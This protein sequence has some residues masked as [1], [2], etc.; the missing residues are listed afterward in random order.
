MGASLFSDF[1]SEFI[2]LASDLEYTSEMLIW[3]FK[4]KLT[5]CLQDWLNSEIE[6]LKTIS[7]LAKYY[8]SIYKQMQATNQIREKAKSFTIV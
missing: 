4:Y 1:Y 3:E 7:A 5:P 2:R 6:L 8:L